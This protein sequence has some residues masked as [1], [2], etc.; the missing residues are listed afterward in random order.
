[1]LIFKYMQGNS[2]LNLDYSTNTFHRN[3][4]EILWRVAI[5]NPVNYLPFDNKNLIW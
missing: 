5:S 4:A 1:M 2:R 3:E